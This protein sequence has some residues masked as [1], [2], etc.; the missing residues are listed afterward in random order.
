MCQLAFDDLAGDS[1]SGNGG[2]HES[3]LE[4]EVIDNNNQYG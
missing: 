3:R 2:M 1:W 4:E